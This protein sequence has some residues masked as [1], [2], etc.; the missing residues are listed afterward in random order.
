M[1]QPF[2]TTHFA[3]DWQ[4]RFAVLAIEFGGIGRMAVEDG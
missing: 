2:K 1:A 3:G 4:M